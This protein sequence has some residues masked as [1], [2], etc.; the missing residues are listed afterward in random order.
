[1]RTIRRSLPSPA[2]V[3][4]FAGPLAWFADTGVNYAS[5]GWACARDFPLVPVVAAMALAVVLAGGIVSIREWRRAGMATAP[6]GGT[7][8]RLLAGLGALAAALFGITIL[9]H[10]AAGL[11]FSGCER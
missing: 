8:E 7:P 6:L 1:M 10:G 11:V 5:A 4:L 3:V 9:L 2:A